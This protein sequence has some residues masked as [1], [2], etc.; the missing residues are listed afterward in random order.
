MCIVSV[1]GTS[2]VH[3]APLHYLDNVVIFS[4]ELSEV[5]QS[6][7][8]Q[9]GGQGAVDLLL[10][11]VLTLGGGEGSYWGSRGLGSA[12]G[13]EETQDQHERRVLH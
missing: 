11:L 6:P 10:D 13:G 12:P 8:G 1:S 4:E 5:D 3:I 9:T 2:V 7:P